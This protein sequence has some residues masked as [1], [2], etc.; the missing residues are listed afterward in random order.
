MNKVKFLDFTPVTKHFTMRKK[1]STGEP[2]L[3]IISEANWLNF[4]EGEDGDE[5]VSHPGEYWM[6]S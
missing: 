5:L 4:G 2:V 3:I 6:K 1:D